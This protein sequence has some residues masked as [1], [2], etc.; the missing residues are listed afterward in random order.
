MLQNDKSQFNG[1]NGPQIKLIQ[2]HWVMQ[3]KTLRRWLVKSLKRLMLLE[4][5]NLN[6]KINQ[7]KNTHQIEEIY[8]TLGSSNQFYAN[9]NI[10]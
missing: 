7:I 9:S 4:L 5:T 3:K 8:K 6:L 10:P 1:K 2:S